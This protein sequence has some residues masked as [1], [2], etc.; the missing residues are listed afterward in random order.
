MA[1]V[2]NND[3]P[4]F[5]RPRKAVEQEKGPEK[6]PLESKTRSSGSLESEIFD[7]EN[8]DRTREQNETTENAQ[9]RPVALVS[10]ELAG[11][12][13]QAGSMSILFVWF[14]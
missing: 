11:P 10:E 3:G 2:A 6:L 5:E 9:E 7:E 8:R 14:R 13:E 12:V 4:Y 1:A